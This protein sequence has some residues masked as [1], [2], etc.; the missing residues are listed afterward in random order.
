MHVQAEHI[1]N[2]NEKVSKVLNALSNKIKKQKG[3][4]VLTFHVA[5]E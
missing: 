3:K 2:V 4:A 5:D 1:S